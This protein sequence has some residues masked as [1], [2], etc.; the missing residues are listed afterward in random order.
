MKPKLLLFCGWGWAASSP[1]IY[2][3]QR[4]LK[5]A[6]FGYTKTFKYLHS[7]KW[8]NNELSYKHSSYNNAHRILEKHSQGIWEN[9]KSDLPGTHML[10]LRVDLEPLDDFPLDHLTQ[11]V[12]GNPSIS[13]YMDFFHALHDHVITKGYKSV[14]DAY[15][16]RTVRQQ[17]YRTEDQKNK[18]ESTKQYTETLKSEFDVK[19]LCITRD[20][21][22]RAFSNYICRLQKIQDASIYRNEGG[23]QK[24]E[25]PAELYIYDYVYEINSIRKLFKDNFHCIV[26][27]ELW[28][29]D[30]ATVLSEF[31]EHPIKKSDLWKNLYAPD[32]GHLIKFDKDVPC[33]AVG[34]DLLEL[35]PEMYWYYRKKYNFVYEKWKSTFGSLPLYWGEP[36]EY[37]A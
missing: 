23:Y 20:P 37:K 8:K 15:M 2:T 10:N 22:R 3:L 24:E 18:I 13:K 17:D 21:V 33:Q 32:K 25:L 6:H 12:T 31:L 14:G 11:L 34:Q 4:N 1:L 29:G 30:G 27:E 26:M 9:Y 36:I 16:G 35:T 5:Y 19:V 7:P 28:E